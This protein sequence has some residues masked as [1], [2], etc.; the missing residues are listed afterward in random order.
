MPTFLFSIYNVAIFIHVF[1]WAFRFVR[2]IEMPLLEESRVVEIAKKHNKTARQVL[3]RHG[4]QRGI[5]V[6]F[7]SASEVRLKT[8]IQVKTP[9]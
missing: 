9:I 8:N 4:I 6:L 3:L 1:Y 5:V 2:F 7:K